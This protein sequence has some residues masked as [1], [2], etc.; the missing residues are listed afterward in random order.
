MNKKELKDFILKCL[1]E[2][3]AT[4]VNCM[5][6]QGEV[7]LAD[8]MI[9]ASGR[10]VNNI[11]AIGEFIALE[12]KHNLKWNAFVEGLQGSDWILIDAGIVIV[13]LFHPEAREQMKLEELW[14]ERA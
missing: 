12:L 11:R 5:E 2:K 8:Y 4:D 1:E 13:H 14:K 3:N 6:I 7:P 9:F 10:S